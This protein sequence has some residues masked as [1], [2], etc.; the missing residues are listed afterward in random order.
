MWMPEYDYGSL[1]GKGT[2]KNGRGMEL[3]FQTDAETFPGFSSMDEEKARAKT[4]LVLQIERKDAFEPDEQSVHSQDDDVSYHSLFTEDSDPELTKEYNDFMNKQEMQS[5]LQPPNRQSSPADDGGGPPQAAPG[6]M[7]RVFGSMFTGSCMAGLTSAIYNRTAV[8]KE[9]RERTEYDYEAQDL[10]QQILNELIQLQETHRLNE[11][12]AEKHLKEHK[13]RCKDPGLERIQSCVCN[14]AEQF[15]IRCRDMDMRITPDIQ[16][17]S[18][19]LRTL[20]ETHQALR[21]TETNAAIVR[22]L[23]KGTDILQSRQKSSNLTA[24]DVTDVLDENTDALRESR[25]AQDAFRLAISGKDRRGALRSSRTAQHAAAPLTGTAARLV[26]TSATQSEKDDAQEPANARIHPDQYDILDNRLAAM[27]S[28]ASSSAK[29]T[30]RSTRPSTNP[31]DV[32][33][34]ALLAG[35]G[36]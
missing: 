32:D 28:P 14:S 26:S 20:S 5:F 12:D 10:E 8:G 17:K 34:D 23:K 30:E 22:V 35:N 31:A 11:E 18:A 6:F 7:S 24:D 16:T 27:S 29:Q 13:T 33:L 2:S 21:T 4:V 25:A 1:R 36:G 15:R 19:Q 3:L 9:L